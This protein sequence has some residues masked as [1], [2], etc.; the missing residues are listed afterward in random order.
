LSL[1]QH[2]TSVYVLL[3]RFT[4]RANLNSDD[5]MAFACAALL[6]VCRWFFPLGW[7]EK[8]TYNKKESTALPQARIT[9]L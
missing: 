1:R 2:G 4:L 7:A 8:T 5:Q 9:S 6:A 3:F